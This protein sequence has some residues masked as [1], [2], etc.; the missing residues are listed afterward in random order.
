MNRVYD[1][2]TDATVTLSDNHL[3]SD[4]VSDSYGSASFADAN[5]GT[6]K[7]VTVTGITISG[8]DAGNYT[9]QNTTATTTANITPAPTTV[10]VSAP[11]PS[12]YGQSVSFTATV[13]S[14][15]SGTV[16]ANSV[17]FLIDGVDFGPAVSL[18]S[19]V[20]T[21]LSIATLGAASH[22]ITADYLGDLDDSP[23]SGTGTQVVNQAPLYVTASNFDIAHGDVIPTLTDTITGFISGES[24]GNVTITGS[25]A[26]ATTATSTSP[27]G[28]YAI[29]V[30]STGMSAANYTFVPV[31]GTLTVHPKVLDVIVLY[32]SRSMSIENLT[33]DLPF[34][35]IS[36]IEILFSD[37]VTATGSSATLKSS[38]SSGTLY[39]LGT[40]GYTSSSD[41]AKWT[42]PSALGI[43]RYLLNLD[44]TLAAAVD[45]TINIMGTT[46]WNFSVLPGDF[47]GDG[48][49]GTADL[50]GVH[51]QMPQYLGTTQTA[52]VWADING[53]GVVDV[54]DYNLVK[55]YLNTK[56]PP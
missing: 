48:I 20:A 10:G 46:S 12:T 37:N 34:S 14:S 7:T 8:T 36:A 19:G 2:N 49:V 25:P 27:A 52:S 42:L 45:H 33:R 4:S 54:N 35:D 15:V 22:V 24:S 23:N 18:V 13:T 28:R 31:N 32:G 50:T 51:S 53:D 47:D 38:T 5:V 41:E 40:F 39:N 1:A 56:L 3:G 43:D 17:Q 44:N 6:G 21:S 55:K 9:L 11:S 29:T 30:N 26:L 16:P